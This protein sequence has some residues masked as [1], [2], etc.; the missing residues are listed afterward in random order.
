[1][2]PAR[3]APSGPWY[4]DISRQQWKQFTASWLGYLLDGFDFVLITLVLSEIAKEF[5]LGTV[6]SAS[7][8]SA[9][10]ISRWFG[11]LALGA[12]GDRYGRKTAMIV[13][14]ILFSLGS[15]ACA[16]APSYWVLFAARLVIGMGM[17]GEYGSSST[18]VIESW[19]SHLRNKASGFLISGYS[20]GTIIAAQ[21]YRFVV[22][23]FGWRALFVIGLLP[24]AITLWLRRALPESEDWKAAKSAASS[25]SDDHVPAPNVFGVLFA[26]RH[27]ALNIISAVVAIVLLSLIFGQLMPNGFAVAAG[28]AVLA[29]VFISYI[30]QFSKR[31]WPAVLAVTVTVFAAFLYSWP[32]QSLLPTYLSTDLGYDAAHVSNA[33]FFAGFG[34]AV[35]CWVAGFTG[36][37][38]GTRWAYVGSLL[39]SEVL[40]F[41]L[42]AVGGTSL[43]VLGLFLFVQQVFGQGIAGLLPKWIGGFFPTEQRA[44]GLG[45]TYNVGALGGAVAPILGASLAVQFSSLGTALAVISFSLTAVVILLMAFNVPA[46]VQRWIH[47]DASWAGDFSRE[48]GLSIVDSDPKVVQRVG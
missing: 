4:R 41:P 34:A 7:L 5:H 15:V 12:L 13:S 45:F 46:R 20:I 43:M 33:L 44:A 2:S 1:M 23:E 8:I 3:T 48:G 28:A 47:P 16:A 19:P 6:Q 35:G 31:R 21:V 36:D 24:I 42:F 40:V 17:A 27:R 26:G 38:L 18:Y 9:A 25:T 29:A 39:L 32:I 10:F 11:G 22:P 37:W 30:V 14:I